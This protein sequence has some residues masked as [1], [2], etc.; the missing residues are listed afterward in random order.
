MLM[1]L[2]ERML[3]VGC[4]KSLVEVVSSERF[5]K[6]VKQHA[7]IHK[8]FGP[9]TRKGIALRAGHL[10]MMRLINTRSEKEAIREARLVPADASFDANI[11]SLIQITGESLVAAAGDCLPDTALALAVEWKRA[12]PDRRFEIARELYWMFRH[13]RQASKG[14]LSMA[15]IWEK[16]DRRLL[17]QRAERE[18]KAILPRLYGKWDAISSVA[19]CQGVCQM[20]V[21]F[22]RKAGARV[23]ALSPIRSSLD[24]LCRARSTVR[25]EVDTDLKARGLTNA[26]AGFAEGIK[27]SY[28]EDDFQEEAN[29]HITVAIEICDDRWVLVDPYHL[30]WGEFSPQWDLPEVYRKLEKYQAVLPGLNILSHDHGQ[31]RCKVDQLAREARALVER[32]REIEEA[33]KEKVRTL[34]DLIEFIAGSDD[35]D[36]YMKYEAI[37]RGMEPMDLSSPQFR[38]GVAS[39]LVFGVEDV[40]PSLSRL[41]NPAEL[42]KAIKLWIT[43]FH[44]TAL[45]LLK[46]N[47]QE[48]GELIHPAC[49]FYLPEYGIALSALN[50]LTCGLIEYPKD[51]R[52]FFVD[53]TADQIS[54]SNALLTPIQQQDLG[55][56][57]VATQTLQ[58][59]PFVHPICKQKLGWLK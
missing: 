30:V 26:D 53:H 7:S 2:I 46:N 13:E 45:N 16:M 37:E 33:I 40:F 52:R 5:G 38:L 48:A 14:D 42:S 43:A 8:R 36:V 4:G 24:E 34:T 17:R 35:L 15:V 47:L 59:L 28:F 10:Q 31:A 11:R 20:L 25:N 55:L 19:N 29:F 12:N 41:L 9:R 32:S 49:E 51:M 56:A 3:V 54:L 39:L 22:A 44:A 6:I 57:R 23:V 18:D 27:A 58:A 1:K 21:A 50:S